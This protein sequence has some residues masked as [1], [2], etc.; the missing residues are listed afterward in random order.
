MSSICLP[1][2]RDLRTLSFSFQ[3]P[4][5]KSC[6]FNALLLPSLKANIAGNRNIKVAMLSKLVEFQMFPLRFRDEAVWGETFLKTLSFLNQAKPQH[7]YRNHSMS[8]HWECVHEEMASHVPEGPCLTGVC[9][10]FPKSVIHLLSPHIAWP[11]TFNQ[12]SFGLVFGLNRPF[13]NV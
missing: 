9:A 1:Y 3:F 6:I 8:S 12:L 13:L 11:L 2:R 4:I 10:R 7:T 5:C